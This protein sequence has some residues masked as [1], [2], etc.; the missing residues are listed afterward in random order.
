M[1]LLT[2][3]LALKGDERMKK[4]ITR[5]RCPT[6][7]SRKVAYIQYGFPAIS[8]EFEEKLNK[9]EIVLGGCIITETNGRWYCRSC[10]SEFGSAHCVYVGDDDTDLVKAHCHSMNNQKE[11]EESS[12]CGC[13][14]CLNVYPPTDIKEWVDDIGDGQT[15][16]CPHC[17]VD[18]VIGD[19]SGYPVTDK[20]FLEA[21][22]DRWMNSFIQFP[23]E[24]EDEEE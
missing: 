7:G 18:S 9:K 2:I 16:I 1:Q 20:A 14:Y 6:C 23:E 17:L 13:F 4:K 8:D 15:A 5:P 10:K 19:K 11:I 21:M 3:T 24:I 12:L 22:K